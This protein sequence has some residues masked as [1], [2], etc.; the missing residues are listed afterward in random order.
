MKW[1]KFKYALGFIVILTGGLISL[2]LN[3]T[4]S[5]FKDFLLGVGIIIDFLASFYLVKL[6]NLIKK[7]RDLRER[8]VEKQELVNFLETIENVCLILKELIVRVKENRDTLASPQKFETVRKLEIESGIIGGEISRIKLLVKRGKEENERLNKLIK[9]IDQQLQG[10]S[11]EERSTEEL[12]KGF[13]K[14]FKDFFEKRN[15]LEKQLREKEEEIKKKEERQWQVESG[16]KQIEIENARID[17]TLRNLK[18]EIQPY[19]KFVERAKTVRK[20][21]QKLQQEIQSKQQRLES[22]GGI[23]LRALE[24]YE[25]AKAE[26]DSIVEKAN[27]LESEKGEILNVI[28]EIDKRKK[29]EF[30]KT[31][32]AIEENFTR[33]FS[34]LAVKGQAFLELENKEN[35]FKEGY[36][37]DIRIKL[38]RGKYLDTRSLSGGE[39]SLTALSFIFAIQEYKPHHFYLLD[40]VDAALDKRNSERL[41]LLIKEYVK[42]A[43][44]I[45]ITHNDAMIFAADKLY[46]VSMQNGASKVVSLKL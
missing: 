17:E 25:E 23:N 28:T 43:Q 40:E 32:T 3:D 1:K 37:I 27:K 2:T 9:E 12:E 20:S 16:L 35:P 7:I 21:E 8:K 11:I 15:K 10:V 29:K 30:M 18:E 44:Y 19:E 45:S 24:V 38:G 39:K 31:F 36:G 26:F 33:I 34:K 22:L 42:K 5:N 14:R 4:D 13:E 6:N 46:G 41:A